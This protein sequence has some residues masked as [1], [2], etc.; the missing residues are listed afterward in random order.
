MIV[1]FKCTLLFEMIL[2]KNPMKN[3]H[4]SLALFGMIAL[5]TQASTYTIERRIAYCATLDFVRKHNPLSGAALMGSRL[6]ATEARC[7]E[8]DP[9]RIAAYQK[10]HFK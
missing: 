10:E 5:F 2:L 3:P 4:L 1:I 8:I 9:K 7:S 6:G